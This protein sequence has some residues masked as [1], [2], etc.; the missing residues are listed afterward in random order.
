MWNEA[1]TTLIFYGLAFVSVLA[2]LA[3]VRTP[4]ILRAAMALAGVLICSAGFYILLDFEFLAGIQVLV[5]VGGI[6]ILMI[7][8]IMLTSSVEITEEE[9]ALHRQFIGLITATC[10]FVVS[11]G[12]F[13]AT[14]FST[15]QGQRVPINDVVLLGRKF[16]DYSSEGYVLPFEIISLLLLSVMIGGIIIARKPQADGSPPEETSDGLNSTEVSS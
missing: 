16:L 15:F 5:Y 11:A 13:I 14:D 12:V 9:P 4:K 8:A 6:V 2:A 10:F 1:A 3:V 7:F